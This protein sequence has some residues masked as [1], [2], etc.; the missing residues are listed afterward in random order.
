LIGWLKTPD[1]SASE[2]IAIWPRISV[3]T[4]SY[5]QAQY[6]EQTI[7]SVLS[8]DYPNLEYLL[9][10]G[11]STDGSA[12][13]IRRYESRLAYSASERDK[14]QTDAIN[15]GLRHATGD[16]LAYLNSDDYY[17]PGTLKAVAEHFRLHADVD[18]VHGRCRYVDKDGTKVGEQFGEIQT[19]CQMLDLWNVWWNRRQ[20]VQPEVFWTRRVTEKVGPFREELHFV[21]DYDYWLRVLRVGGQISRLDRELACFRRTPDQK[22]TQSERVADELLQVVHPELWDYST[23]IPWG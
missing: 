15:K 3:I 16:I 5:N 10:D 18:L 17:L 20:F 14:G 13:I 22:S 19:Y 11:G 21:M 1:P 12:D 2:D 6:L 23:Q 4:P 7:E 9:V 8:Q